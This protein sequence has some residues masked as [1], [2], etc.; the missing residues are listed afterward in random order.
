MT[1]TNPATKFCENLTT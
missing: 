1:Q